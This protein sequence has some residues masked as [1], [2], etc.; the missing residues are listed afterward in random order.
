MHDAGAAAVGGVPLAHL[1]SVHDAGA[2]AGTAGGTP[3]AHLGSVPGQRVR[4]M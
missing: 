1:G 4:V 3:L 2:G